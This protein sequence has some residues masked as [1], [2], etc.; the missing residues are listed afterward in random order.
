MQQWWEMKRDFFDTLLFF[1]VG[2]FYEIFHM[3]ADICVKELEIVYMKGGK[4]HCGFPEIAFSKFSA[5][6]VDRG[7]IPPSSSFHDFPHFLSISS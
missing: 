2:K 7:K 5:I 4:A 3:D 6:L 1:K